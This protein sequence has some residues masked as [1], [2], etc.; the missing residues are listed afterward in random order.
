MDFVGLSK[1]AVQ[2][3]VAV[4][5]Y[6]SKEEGFRVETDKPYSKSSPVRTTLYCKRG[7]EVWLVEVMDSLAV[8]PLL[9]ELVL[10]LAHE[11]AK[12][13]VL[14]AVGDGAILPVTAM[15]QLARRGIGV[16]VVHDD[17]S[18]Q[19]VQMPR[20]FA[21]SVPI[22]KGPGLGHRQAEIGR[23]QRRYNDGSRL[24]A[25]RELCEVIES[26]VGKLASRL[27]ERGYIDVSVKKVERMSFE[28]QIDVLDEDERWVEGR[29]R[30]ADKKLRNDLQSFR[31]ARNL[32]SHPVKSAKERARRDSQ[33]HERMVQGPR[34]VRELL[35]AKRNA[36]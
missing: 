36:K 30:V 31:G 13:G 29:K 5:E 6:L 26:E 25:A 32:V 16:L 19:P 28:Q 27:A 34:L 23:I 11:Q 1:S 3:A 15:R 8:D 24:D 21:Y 2:V 10:D 4:A 33:L 14:V 35:A 7:D 17:G 9:D 12:A 22:D 18:V 20:I